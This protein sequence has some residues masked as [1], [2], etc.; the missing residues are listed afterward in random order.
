MLPAEVCQEKMASFDGAAGE[1][2]FRV[3]APQGKYI[4]VG[5][6]ANELKL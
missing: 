6:A 3:K 4:L 2:L 1:Y 5:W